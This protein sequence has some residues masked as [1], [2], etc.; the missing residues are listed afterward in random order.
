MWVNIGIVFGY[1]GFWHVT[2][3]WMHWGKR[4]FKPDRVWSWTKVLHN[5]YYCLLGAVQYTAW[6]AI[7]MYCYATGKE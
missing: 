2:L 6:E 4:P 5:C 3:Y 7:F 1:F